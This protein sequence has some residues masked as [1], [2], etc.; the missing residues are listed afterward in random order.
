MILENPENQIMLIGAMGS[1]IATT[2]SLTIFNISV[3]HK[4][5]SSGITPVLTAALIFNFSWITSLIYIISGTTA[6]WI[7]SIA[8][9]SLLIGAMFI[10][11]TVLIYFIK[12]AEKQPFDF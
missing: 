3:T 2:L 5:L 7:L 4:F 1:I 6:S 8:I 11:I 9:H 12:I 10:L